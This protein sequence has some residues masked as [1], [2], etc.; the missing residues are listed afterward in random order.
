MCRRIVD[1]SRVQ[2]A[3]FKHKHQTF[4][5]IDSGKQR[6]KLEVT[7]VPTQLKVHKTS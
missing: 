6:H 1:Y 5:H 4:K 2:I 7:L 3:Y